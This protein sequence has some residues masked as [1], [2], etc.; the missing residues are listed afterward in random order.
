MPSTLRELVAKAL[1]MYDALEAV[2]SFNQPGLWLCQAKC[3]HLMSAHE[4]GEE[5][6]RL[7]DLA[8]AAYEKVR[9]LILKRCMCVLFG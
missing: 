7:V 5:R 3:Y 2:E 8:V 1:K 9:F 4:Q 6:K